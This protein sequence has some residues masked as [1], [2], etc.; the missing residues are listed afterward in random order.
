MTS[1]EMTID[2]TTKDMSSELRYGFGNVL[3]T[4]NRLTKLGFLSFRLIW[5]SP[6]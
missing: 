4:Q 5:T 3:G 2:L 6:S 1:R